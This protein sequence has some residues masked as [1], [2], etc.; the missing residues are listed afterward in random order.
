[1]KVP[2][3]LFRMADYNEWLQLSPSVVCCTT[4]SLGGVSVEKRRGR[5]RTRQ[6]GRGKYVKYI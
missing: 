1:M 2:Q 6:G 4:C 5:E 3:E